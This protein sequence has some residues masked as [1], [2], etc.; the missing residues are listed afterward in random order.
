M[1]LHACADRITIELLFYDSLFAIILQT[2]FFMASHVLLFHWAWCRCSAK[3]G[4][5]SEPHF[6]CQGEEPS[7]SPTCDCNCLL[8]LAEGE[9]WS[10]LPNTAELTYLIVVLMLIYLNS[11]IPS[12]FW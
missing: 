9:C 5:P 10:L 2:L 6:H 12:I 1:N 11:D 4:T 8:S 7:M 3:S